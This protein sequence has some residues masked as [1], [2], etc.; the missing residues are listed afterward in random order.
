MQGTMVDNP[1]ARWFFFGVLNL[2]VLCYIIEMLVVNATGN[3]NGKGALFLVGSILFIT[4]K[5]IAIPVA[6]EK[7]GGV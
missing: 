4:S 5:S 6:L 7:V 1:L 2:T 3:A